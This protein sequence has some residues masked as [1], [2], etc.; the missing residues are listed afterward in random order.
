M[1]KGQIDV[2]KHVALYEIPKPH[3]KITIHYALG[4][5]YVESLGLFSNLT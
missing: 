1:T 3:K 5:T 2:Y 4:F